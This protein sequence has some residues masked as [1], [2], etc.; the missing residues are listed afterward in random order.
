MYIASTCISLF[1]A[2]DNEE[3]NKKKEIRWGIW[4]RKRGVGR[5][6]KR[7]QEVGEEMSRKMSEQM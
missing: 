5:N 3:E 7:A 6:G 4:R 1:P 2:L